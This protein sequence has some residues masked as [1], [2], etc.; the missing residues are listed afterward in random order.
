[1]LIGHSFSRDGKC[2]A[3]RTALADHRELASASRFDPSRQPIL[4]RLTLFRRSGRRSKRDASN[5]QNNGEA[6]DSPPR[7]KSFQSVPGC[8]TEGANRD[9]EMPIAVIDK[10]TTIIA[11]ATGIFFSGEFSSL[12]RITISF[13]FSVEKIARPLRRQCKSHIQ[14]WVSRQPRAA[15]RQYKFTVME[16]PMNNPQNASTQL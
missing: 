4:L 11:I 12:R 7:K 5:F 6:Q 14:A 15:R 16:M 10:P 3:Y 13:P 9:H 1:M 2:G 8:G